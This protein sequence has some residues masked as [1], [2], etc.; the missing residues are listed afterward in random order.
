MSIAQTQPSQALPGKK[1]WL[2]A[3]FLFTA[4]F[5]NMLDTTIVNLALP[6]IQD[7]LSA[8]HSALQ[9]VL[10]IYAL[11]FAAGLLPFGRFGDALGR[12]HLFLVGLGGFTLASIAC[13]VA[14]TI[15]A[16]VV[17]RMAQG[18]AASMMMPQV[19]AILHESF[20][21]NEKAKAI[22]LFGMITALGAMA[23]PLVGG[24]LI[25]ANLFDL[26]WRM[27]FLINIPIGVAALAGAAA[28]LPGARA[29]K[30]QTVDWSGA[31]LFAGASVALLY[32]MIEG[33]ALGWPSWLAAV[34]L[35]SFL[36]MAK[37]WHHQ[38]RL[39]K[40]GRPQL[41]PLSLLE[42][43]RF[44]SRIGLVTLMFAGIAGPI[45]V[46]AMVLQSGL[47]LSPAQAGIALAAHPLSIMLASILTSRVGGRHVA[48]RASLGMVSLL[49]G[50]LGLKLLMNDDV[51]VHVV[52]LPL[53]FVGAGMGSAA[54]AMYQ[55]VL[56]E[57][58]VTDAGAGSG[59]LQ[60]FQQ[61][62][63]ALGIALVSQVFFTVLG[64]DPT[65]AEFIEALRAA[66][67]LPVAIYAA[68]SVVIGA[69]H[70]KEKSY[71]RP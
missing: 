16:L 1:H 64:D 4:A 32:P 46:L 67:W 40:K 61:I 2:G 68:L 48:L 60:A 39:A 59:A 36:L 26:A 43:A 33:H 54:V 50:M 17:S 25:S 12:R 3:A 14:P 22:G 6:S 57:V 66:L 37:F 27:I 53:V 30:T 5:I 24:F 23:G 65:P 69:L 70:H 11:T 55:L 38:Q 19:L 34:F 51:P 52:W 28:F 35:L 7:D 42:N 15:E 20:P 31:F 29:A 10:V 58:P 13:G 8:S 18:L 63:I 41:L 71:A 9:W 47:G 62:G 21:E 45:V 44:L 49:I 56:N